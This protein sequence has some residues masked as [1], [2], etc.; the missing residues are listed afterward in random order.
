MSVKLHH[1][2]GGTVCFGTQEVSGAF[3]WER[4]EATT[5]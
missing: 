3:G 2:N 1:A 4:N 5:S